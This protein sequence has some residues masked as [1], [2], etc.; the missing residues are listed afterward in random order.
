MVL[1]GFSALA[2]M[3]SFAKG[4]SALDIFAGVASIVGAGG[5]L[6]TA[7]YLGRLWLRWRVP[8][9]V[10]FFLPKNVYARKEFPGAP[11][12]ET[13]CDS[14]NIGTGKYAIFVQITALTH[15]ELSKTRF[16]LD[17]HDVARRPTDLGA[18]YPGRW[19]QSK[20]PDWLGRQRFIDWNGEVRLSQEFGVPGVMP[21]G[22]TH[23]LNKIIEARAEWDGHIVIAVPIQGR[24]V[25]AKDYRLPLKVT[26]DRDDVPFLRLSGLDT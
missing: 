25:R 14:L 13:F 10:Q 12:T 5:I 6:V 26:K 17:E 2:I 15:V 21:R 11:T 22:D 4:D 9:R 16:L 19:A 24:F 18:D 7:I 3:G 23:L 20:D 8:I 1:M